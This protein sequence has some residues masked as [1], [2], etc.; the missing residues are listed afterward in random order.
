M[1]RHII[2]FK[3]NPEV[4]D[5]QIQRA[6]EK[7]K[8][9]AAQPYISK[10]IATQSIGIDVHP[11]SERFDNTYD[12]AEV[13]DFNTQQDLDAYVAHPLHEELKVYFA[14]LAQLVRIN[15]LW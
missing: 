2:L 12:L 13:F 9:F 4:S 3:F 1:I 7:L 14:P 10:L 11:R 15:Y 5:E 6:V 8:A